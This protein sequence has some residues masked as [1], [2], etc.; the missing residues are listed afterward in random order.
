MRQFALLRTLGMQERALRAQLLGEGAVL[1]IAGSALGL[2]L[3]YGIAA[4][5]IRFVGGDLGSGFFQGATPKLHFS[6]AAALLFFLFG[7]ATALGGSY[8]PARA[9]ARIAP[10]DALKNAGDVVDPRQR[11]RLAPALLLLLA[12]AAAAFLP[13][14]GRLP[15]FGYLAVALVLAGGVAA[16]PWLARQ[17]LTPLAR[18]GTGKPPFELALLRL[19]G[20]PSQA[21]TALGGIVA[22]T[23]LMIAMAVMVTSFRG[24]VDEWLD[25]F[26]SADLYV[27]AS[28][29]E[30]LF[31]P[32]LQA[33]LSATP[34]VGAI[35]FSKS[36][37]MVLDPE[38]PPVELIVRPVRGPGYELPLIDA[39]EVGAARKLWFS[40]PAARLYGVEA[41]DAVTLP[42]G[43]KP[44]PFR[45]A[46]IWRDYARQQGA[47]LIDTTD[48]EALTGD[49]VRSEAAVTLAP[50][51]STRNVQAAL[52]QRLPP[53]IAARMQMAEP[54]VLRALALRLFDRSFAITYVLEAIAILIGLAGVA[55]TT[56]AQTIARMKEFGMLRHVGMTPR[57]IMAMLASE[58]ALLG[59]IGIAAGIAL[60]LAISQILI[61]VINPQSFN[62]T[63]ETRLPFGLLAT[64]AAALVATSA[65]TAVLAG[66]RALSASAVRAVSEDW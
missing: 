28:T 56:S 9:A 41:G 14:I 10:A 55:A 22:S 51:A 37:R 44:H 8:A 16:M 66:R 4:L 60:G 36:L 49:R 5:A 24:S 31:D 65:L 15:L 57:Q 33:R 39:A 29:N 62:W 63:M 19:L 32:A 34:G 20:A 64:V 54:A 43:G 21:A 2:A 26:L 18:A 11:P 47:I 6:P 17:V 30:P 25:S 61:H 52:R 50:G 48:Y 40:E 46:G 45:V 27:A 23:G 38:L 58:G 7:L 42:I 53:E 12:G 59:V 35:A 1:G 3:G 13:A